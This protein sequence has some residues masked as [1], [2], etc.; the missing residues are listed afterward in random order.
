MVEDSLLKALERRYRLDPKLIDERAPRNTV[1]VERLGL[2][3]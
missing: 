2:A 3:S 1:H